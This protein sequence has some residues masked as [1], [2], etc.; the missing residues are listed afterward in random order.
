MRELLPD[1]ALKQSPYKKGTTAGYFHRQFETVK[2]ELYQMFGPAAAMPELE[3]MGVVDRASL[4]DAINRYSTGQEHRL[5]AILHC[6]LE[7]ERWLAH[8]SSQT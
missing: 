8:R 7:S 1:S 4:M 5:G 6:T 2:K 3:R